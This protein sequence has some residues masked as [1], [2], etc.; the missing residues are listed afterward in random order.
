MLQRILAGHPEIQTSA[1]TWLMLHP[2]YGLRRRGIQTEYGANWAA[3][4]VSEFL[5]YYADG[6][7]T[8]DN[9]IRA[10]AKEIYGTVLAR[11]GKSYFVDKTPR[12]TLIVPDLYRLFPRAKFILLFRNPLAVLAS[13]LTTYIKGDWPK[14]ANFAPDLLDAPHRLIE[15]RDLLEEKAILLRYEDLVAAPKEQMQRVCHSLGL[16]FDPKMLDYGETPAPKGVMNDPVGVHRHQKPTGASVDKWIQMGS[17]PQTRHLALAYLDALGAETLERLGYPSDVLAEKISNVPETVQRRAI[18]PWSLA[19]RPKRKWRL[20]EAVRGTYFLSAQQN[21]HLRA[22]ID[23]IGLLFA[24]L[25][26][27]SRPRQH[28]SIAGRPTET[29]SPGESPGPVQEPRS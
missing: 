8:Y 25:R 12:Y 5:A 9:A 11:N 14:L 4:G 3:T 29:A 1:E 24:R 15:A 23:A 21:G 19:I 26:R 6:R 7:E 2:V 27:A 20:A 13:E 17:D 18:F 22:S 16:T 10:F 28:G